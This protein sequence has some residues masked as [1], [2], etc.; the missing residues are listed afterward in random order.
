MGTA[1]NLRRRLRHRHPEILRSQPVPPME[2]EAVAATNA[3]HLRVQLKR[4]TSRNDPEDDQRGARTGIKLRAMIKKTTAI[5]TDTKRTVVLCDPDIALRHFLDITLGL[6]LSPS[7]P[8]HLCHVACYQ[9]PFERASQRDSEYLLSTT[10]GLYVG[11]RRFTV[12]TD[13]DPLCIPTCFKPV[14]LCT[15]TLHKGTLL[16]KRTFSGFMISRL[17]F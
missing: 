7:Y 5:C 1:T 3:V 9:P 16:M 14:L 12:L 6:L 4:P 15:L 17:G 11:L 2:L 8:S 10:F 13:L